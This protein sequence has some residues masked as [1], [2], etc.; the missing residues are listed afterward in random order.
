MTYFISILLGLLLGFI[1]ETI[2]KYYKQTKEVKT[3]KYNQDIERVRVFNER[4]KDM[5][6]N[7]NPLT[8]HQDVTK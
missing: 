3:L 8:Q 6:T 4:V 7:I 2:V 1:L 5:N